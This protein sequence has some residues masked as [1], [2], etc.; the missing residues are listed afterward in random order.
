MGEKYDALLA[1]SQ[2]EAGDVLIY[3]G[4]TASLPIFASR[5]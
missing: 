3:E 5:R 1:M 4:S 2:T